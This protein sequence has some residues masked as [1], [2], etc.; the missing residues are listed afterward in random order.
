MLLDNL[1]LIARSAGEWESL[2]MGTQFL[3]L[4]NSILDSLTPEQLFSTSQFGDTDALGE[5]CS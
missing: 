4:F 5:K 3:V 1:A 2:W